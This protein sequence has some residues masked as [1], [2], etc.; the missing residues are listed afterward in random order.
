MA[1]L[2]PVAAAAVFRKCRLGVVFDSALSLS[3]L[4]GHSRLVFAA[5]SGTAANASVID[6]GTVFV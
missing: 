6:L 1:S 5:S 4:F 3:P 2:P